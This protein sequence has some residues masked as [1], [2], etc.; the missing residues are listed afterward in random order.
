MASGRLT[1][2]LHI[3]KPPMRRSSQRAAL[4]AASG[5]V[6][7]RT[8]QLYISCRCLEGQESGSKDTA[9]RRAQVASTQPCRS[10][11]AFSQVAPAAAHA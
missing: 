11:A 4:P 2:R 7:M 10:L 9:P 1:T 6:S 5:A 8:A 3:I